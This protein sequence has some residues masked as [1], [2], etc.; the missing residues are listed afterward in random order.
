MRPLILVFSILLFTGS[1]WAV[2]ET[3]TTIAPS[4][5]D[6]LIPID[7]DIRKGTLENGLTYYIKKNAK[8]EKRMELRLVIKAGAIN[9]DPDQNGVAH[10]VEHMLFNGT[11]HFPKNELVHYLERIG[12]RF[13]ADLNA[14]TSEDQTV[15]QLPIPT[16]KTELISTGF[17]VLADWAGRATFD[18]KEIDNERG[19]VLE[20]WRLD[21]GAQMRASKAHRPSIYH[22]SKLEKHD[23][24]GEAEVI[25]KAPHNVIKRFYHDWYRPDLMAVI[26]VGDFDAAQ[27]EKQIKDNFSYLKNPNNPRQ[28]TGDN[29]EVKPNKDPL[30]SVYAD[31]EQT[32]PV[33]SIA[34]KHPAEKRGTFRAY[35]NSF[36][37]NM[38]SS[39]LGE[40]INEILQKKNP[41]F[42]FAGISYGNFFRNTDTFRVFTVPTKSEE[43]MVGYKATLTEVF[44]QIQHGVTEGEYNRAKANLLINLEKLYNNRNKIESQKFAEEFINNFI[45]DTDIPGVEF[46]YKYSKNLAEKIN[47]NDINAMLKTDVTSENMFMIATVGQKKGVVIPT[48][49]ELLNTYQEFKNTEFAAY[50]DEFSDK[51]LL[52]KELAEGSIVKTNEIKEV[53]LT[54]F[55]LSNGIKVL[56]KPTTFNDSEV[57]FKAFSKG[58]N[59][60]VPEKDYLNGEYAAEVINES[61]LAEFN[62][63]T[64]QKLLAGK[65]VGLSPYIFDVEEG[66]TGSSTP[67]DVETFFQLLHLYFTSP[68]KDKEA[69]DA[70]V[71]RT[72]EWVDNSKRDPDTVFYE[73]I[74]YIMSGNDPRSKPITKEMVESLDLEKVFNIYQQRFFDASDFT[75]VFVGAIEIEKF[76]GFLTK[77][78]ASLPTHNVSENFKDVFKETPKQ[79][80]KKYFYKGKEDKSNVI[81]NLNGD[82][83]YNRKN[84]YLLGSLIDILNYRLT[85]NLREEKAKVYS[86]NAHFSTYQYPKSKYIAGISFGCKPSNVQGLIDT[87][88]KIIRDLQTNLPTD[89][90]MKKVKEADTRQYE[91]DLKENR[92]WLSRIVGSYYH[93]LDVKDILRYP[94]LVNGLTKQDI[95]NAA[96][97]YFNLDG[98]KEFVLYPEVNVKNKAK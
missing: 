4:N 59:S 1:S 76:K 34:Y 89:E 97:Q 25:K 29:I 21:Q 78:I 30:I 9:E 52:S 94:V 27:I 95:K 69:F 49:E 8:P 39:I 47:V 68:H 91:I 54:E 93:N 72:K 96:N 13:G 80:I 40:R 44:R 33:I 45:N 41:P 43:L 35:Q 42:Q 36:I 70:F 3:D 48:K 12:V 67:K 20:E 14:Y 53:G 19:V 15:Y 90:D 60:L 56:V 73:Q 74:N 38:E 7:K 17:N 57:L 88:K 51:K 82:F 10:F 31:S 37:H 23:V 26:A 75:F 66:L 77:Y 62:N 85:D 16:D 83:E 79:A 46:E 28:L 64:L 84:I 86:P 24:I 87:V 18:P 2:A 11:Q 55:I 22:G 32:Y 5:L 98:L 50:K 58:G 71:T 92:Y 65:Y 61:G 63:T 81:L 6:A